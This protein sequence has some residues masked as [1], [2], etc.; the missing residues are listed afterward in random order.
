VNLEF[1][2]IN[3]S[4]GWKSS[5]KTMEFPQC[6]RVQRLENNHLSLF[7]AIY[8]IVHLQVIEVEDCSLVLKETFGSFITPSLLKELVGKWVSG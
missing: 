8:I 3:P 6:N 2:I 5:G 7:L 4:S 1:A